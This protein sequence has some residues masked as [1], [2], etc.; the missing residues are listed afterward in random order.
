MATAEPRRHAHVV[1]FPRDAFMEDGEARTMRNSG[2]EAVFMESRAVLLR[3]LRARGAG[4]DAEDILQELW[5]KLSAMQAQGPIADPLAYLHRMA[6]NLMHDRH[7]AAR[8]R[9]RRE[10]TWHDIATASQPDMSDDPSPERV[11][12]ARDTLRRV[13]AALEQLSERSRAI[14]RRFRVDGVG[15]KVIA[16]EEGISVSAVEK[17]LQRAYRTIMECEERL[18]LRPADRTDAREN[19]RGAE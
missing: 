4:A 11:L 6:D 8:R 17:H 5:L 3:F 16:R 2:L 14:F 13:E 18:G 7:R 15:Q 12:V 9:E 1:A 10:M 19:R